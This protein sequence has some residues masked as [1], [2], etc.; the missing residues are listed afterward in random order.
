MES[1]SNHPKFSRSGE[2]NE[3]MIES[4]GL[5]AVLPY[6]NFRSRK[7]ACLVV[8]RDQEMK[9][10][11][12]IRHEILKFKILLCVFA[13]TSSSFIPTKRVWFIAATL[14]DTNCTKFCHVH[15]WL[16]VRLQER[17]CA[18][19]CRG[20]ISGA[21]PPP[22]AAGISEIGAP[23]PPTISK[24]TV[25]Y[26]SS[27]P[28]HCFLSEERNPVWK[29]PTKSLVVSTFGAPDPCTPHPRTVGSAGPLLTPLGLYWRWLC[30]YGECNCMGWRLQWTV[31]CN[32][33]VFDI[34][35][36]PVLLHVWIVVHGFHV[37]WNV[38]FQLSDV[39]QFIW[40]RYKPLRAI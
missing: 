10:V 40:T 32:G 21:E 4:V 24:V 1:H 31:D 16:T 19:Y 2:W 30:G 38:I 37:A 39:G 7:P 27:G 11:A 9:T 22:P 17:N 29:L 36:Q 5:L 25:W 14:N 8:R 12:R 6:T 13:L 23:P 15:N 33:Y 20:F 28:E 26:H 18:L 3:H 35:S 34:R